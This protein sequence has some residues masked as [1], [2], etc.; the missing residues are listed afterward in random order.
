MP[1]L[2]ER[3]LSHSIHETLSSLQSALKQLTPEVIASAEEAG[4][5]SAV[6]RTVVMIDY[7]EGLLATA[8]PRLVTQASLDAVNGPLEQALAAVRNLPNDPATHTATLDQAVEN[9]LQQAAPLASA[10]ASFVKQT[11]KIGR[12][13]GGALT[14]KVKE[15]EGEA[16]MISE[17]LEQLEARR[18]SGLEELDSEQE[19]KRSNLSARLEELH[20]AIE[21]EKQRTGS[22]ASTFQE[23]FSA[24]QD[25]RRNE[26]DETIREI[27]EQSAAEAEQLKEEGSATL[28]E[29]QGVRDKIKELYSVITDTS[30]AGAFHDEA[31]KEARAADLWRRVTLG[32]ATAAAV[33]A[34]AAVAASA[35]LEVSPTLVLTKVAATIAC[36]V[37]A[38][39]AAR[40][41][42]HHRGRADQA[43]DLELELV[44][45]EG[46]LHSIDPA[47][48]RELRQTYFDRA[49]RGRAESH[50][51]AA[52]PKA[53]TEFGLTPDVLAAMS[54]LAKALQAQH[55]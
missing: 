27:K 37:I 29:A 17:E 2:E 46:F 34:V 24:A 43:K 44:A 9:T 26:F 40:Q 4:P 38:A 8:D 23:Q 10:A 22:L 39:Y 48:Q 41:S 25:E 5:S 47:E 6:D 32:F 11:Q 13:L 16:E 19:Q 55:G 45:V 54:A 31:A 35:A 18:K 33:I 12:K 30:T 14:V 49:F 1:R 7:I 50:Q 51:E 28:S 3:L 42:R 21:A 53:S 52:S 15:L 36:G 20:A